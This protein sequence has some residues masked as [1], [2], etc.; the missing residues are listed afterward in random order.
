MT[1]ALPTR[2]KAQTRKLIKLNNIFTLFLYDNCLHIKDKNGLEYIFIL[3][4]MVESKYK[5]LAIKD[6]EW[7]YKCVRICTLTHT[8]ARLLTSFGIALSMCKINRSEWVTT[9]KE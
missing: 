3:Y 1:T 2:Q 6:S 8:H 4:I 9:P 5:Y 7:K